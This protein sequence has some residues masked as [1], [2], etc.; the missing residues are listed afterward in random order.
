MTICGV[1]MSG[2]EVKLVLLQGTKASFNHIDIEP[3]KIKLIDDENPNAVKTFRDSIFAF[4]KENQ[5]ALV[6]IKKR[7]KKG[8]FSG[9]P[10]GFK[11]EGIIQLY[12]ECPVTLLAPQTIS[13][14]QKKHSP[15]KP[16]NLKIY[17]YPAFETA[18]STLT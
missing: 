1:E 17:Q 16:E 11:L 15:E 13:A 3:R 14:A 7:G 6:V 8:Q 18:F 9:G 10:I 12:E 2:S 4:F 5:V